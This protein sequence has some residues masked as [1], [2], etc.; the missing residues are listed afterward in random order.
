M[1]FVDPGRDRHQLDGRN[2]QAAKMFDD[3]GLGQRRDRAAPA[4][5]DIRMQHRE[6][7][8]RDLVDQ[9]AIGEQRRFERDL[10]RRCQ[11]AFRHQRRGVERIRTR[12]A[13]PRVI[14]IGPVDL[15]SARID[16]K[17]RRIEPMTARRLVRAVGAQAVAGACGHA[18]D[19]RG[20][21]VVACPVESDAIELFITRRVE[22]AKPDPLG[23]QRLDGKSRARCLDR[24]AKPHVMTVGRSRPVYLAMPASASAAAINGARACWVSW[25]WSA[26]SG[27]YRSM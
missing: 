11:H 22:Q 15:E 1:A 26:G 17:L 18:R 3:G 10:R 16:E 2:A 27:S 24:C 23:R 13:E 19:E 25:P 8:D 7:A 12:R 5:G 20:E 21:F 9:P 14:T 6:G 4:F